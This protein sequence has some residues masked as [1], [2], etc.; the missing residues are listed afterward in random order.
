MGTLIFQRDVTI[1]TVVFQDPE[2]AFEIDHAFADRA[3]DMGVI[4]DAI[5]FYMHHGNIFCNILQAVLRQFISGN[6]VVADVGSC[7]EKW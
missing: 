7:P 1:K 3:G 2:T 6:P 5:I 4:D